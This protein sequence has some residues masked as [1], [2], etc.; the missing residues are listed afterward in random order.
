MLSGQRRIVGTNGVVGVG[1]YVYEPRDNVD[2]WEVI[3]DEPCVIHI[4]VTGEIEYL[5]DD[6][7]VISRTSATTA[8]AK[9]LDWCVNNNV[10]PLPQLVR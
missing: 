4:E 5:N 1:T 2:S 8:R 7:T 9:Y 3:G 6:D 10:N